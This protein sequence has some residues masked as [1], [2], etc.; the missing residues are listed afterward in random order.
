MITMNMDCT[1]MIELLISLKFI[2]LLWLSVPN[3][4]GATSKN[5]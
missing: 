3:E 4:K 5:L 2:K 1:E